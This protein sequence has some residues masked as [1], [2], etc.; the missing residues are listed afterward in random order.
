[1][2]K[3][4]GARTLAFPV[5]VWVVGTYDAGGRPNVMTASWAGICCSKPPCLNV[6][7]RK[8]TYSFA[9]L[10]ERRAFTVSIPSVDQ[11][12]EADYFGKASGR[13]AD[14]FAATGLTAARSD[15]VDAPYVEEFPLV[16]EC[17]ILHDLEIGLHTL[18]VG[19]ILDVKAYEAVLGE[20]GLP[21]IGAARPFVFA[22]ESR[23]YFAVGER[24]GPAFRMG[25]EFL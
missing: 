17:R 21:D 15:L 16:L 19:E 3:S 22:P 9:A 13:D 10:M 12:K 23:S 2:K 20:K 6:S 11:A 7:L 5:P 18:F 24:L 8:A 1:M 25:S 14:K 4:L